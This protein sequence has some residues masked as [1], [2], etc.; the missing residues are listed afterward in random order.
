[1][2]GLS[3]RLSL[4][5]CPRQA[6]RPAQTRCGRD[7]WAITTITDIG[8]DTAAHLHRHRGHPYRRLDPHFL[9]RHM[10]AVARNLCEMTNVIAMSN[11]HML[12]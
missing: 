7:R 4:K 9:P 10:A 6:Q 5:L 8:T 3:P 11:S 2:D 1:M 12:G